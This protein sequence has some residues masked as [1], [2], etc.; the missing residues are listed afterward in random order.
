[1]QLIYKK[2]TRIKIIVKQTYKNNYRSFEVGI[3]KL[4]V[5]NEKQEIRSG[6]TKK[7]KFEK[8][9]GEVGTAYWGLPA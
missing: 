8:N 3:M 5:R 2:A 1:M 6:R 9:F 4:E 7:K